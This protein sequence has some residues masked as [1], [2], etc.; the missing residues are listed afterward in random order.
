MSTCPSCKAE[1]PAGSKF[2]A[3]C[4]GPLPKAPVPV[5]C[6]A[7]GAESPEGSRFCKGCG[8]PVGGPPVAP[9]GGPSW[10]QPPG[11]GG[12]PGGPAG[13]KAP[14]AS[15]Q[16]IKQL[17]WAGAGLY[18]FAVILMYNS[19]SQQQAMFGAYARVMTNQSTLWFLIVLDAALAALNV[20][21]AAQLGKVSYTLVKGLFA[22]MGVLGIIFLLRSLGAM[23]VL[24][25]FL[26]AGLLACGAY[27]LV[28]AS[29]ETRVRLY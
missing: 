23:Q 16:R 13:P 28:L 24:Y 15:L 14:T 29:R 27:G 8:K 19:V 6:A 11:A 2:C 9:P 25:I 20:Y 4:G 17:L 10:P 21:A 3:G 18:V 7:C 5:R 26:N 12:G 22:A 1:N